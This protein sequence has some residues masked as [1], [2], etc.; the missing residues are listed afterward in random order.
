MTVMYHF[1][2]IYLYYILFTLAQ[3]FFS[4]KISAVGH[5][6]VHGGPYFTGSCQLTSATLHKLEEV[7]ALA[8]LHNPH[9]LSGV[10]AA[11]S[12]FPEA[13]QVGMLKLCLIVHNCTSLKKFKSY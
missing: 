11:A 2:C 5:R 4:N 10:N 7:S 3:H 8:P 13:V 6:I 1:V 9:N 12:S